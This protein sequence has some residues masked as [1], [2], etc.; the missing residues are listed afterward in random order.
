MNSL[1]VYR[2]YRV[3]YLNPSPLALPPASVDMASDVVTAS[4]APITRESSN[5]PQLKPL[6]HHLH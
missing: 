5:A 2:R 3:M 4:E 1:K 6:S